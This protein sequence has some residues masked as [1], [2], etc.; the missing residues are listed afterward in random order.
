M[1]PLGPLLFPSRISRR[2]ITPRFR[3]IFALADENAA[4]RSC[5]GRHRRRRFHF[6]ELA[7]DGHGVSSLP[8]PDTEHVACGKQPQLRALVRD[9]FPQLRRNR[10]GIFARRTNGRRIRRR[11]AGGVAFRCGMLDGVIGAVDRERGG[12]HQSPSVVRGRTGRQC[13]DNIGSRVRDHSVLARNV[14]LL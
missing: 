5:P 4:S 7:L 2:D 6:H 13:A 8:A 11:I 12:V 10:D 14:I 3:L 9:Y 1:K